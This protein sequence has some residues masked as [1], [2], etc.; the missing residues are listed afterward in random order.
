MEALKSNKIECAAEACHEA[1]RI[2]CKLIG[3]DSQV[4]WD[5]APEWQRESAIDGVLSIWENPDQPDSHSH[6]NWLSHKKSDGWVYGPV[7]D[8]EKK[9]HPS[10]VPYDKLP[11][12]EQKKDRVFSTIAKLFA[13]D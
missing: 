12:K 10:M 1:N 11:E 3:D 4:M 13:P 2:Y 9:E 7:K 6:D 5:D 8:A